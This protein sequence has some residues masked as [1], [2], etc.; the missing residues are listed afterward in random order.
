MFIKKI[1]ENKQDPKAHKQFIRFGKGIYTQRVVVNARV[2]GNLLKISSSFELPNDFL[3]FISDLNNKLKV[4][5]IIISKE[6]LSLEN[7]KK[8]SGLYEYEINREISSQEIKQILEK[9]YYLLLDAECP[10]VLFKVKKKLPKP[11]KS[12]EAKVNDKFCVLE[13]DI[14]FKQKFK[15]EF[16]WDIP[17]FK[18]ARAEHTYEIKD[19]IIPNELKKE[20]DFEKIR[21]ESKRK[22]KIIR[23]IIFDGKEILKEKELEI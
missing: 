9:A 2:Q 14:K 10:G 11:G 20:K 17:D 7:E 8:K 13:L 21:L 5:G 6:K 1:W 16:F 18:K 15:E 4:S 12:G 3:E 19:I 23:K 22:G